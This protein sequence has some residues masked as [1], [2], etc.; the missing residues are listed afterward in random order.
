MRVSAA[1]GL[2]LLAGYHVMRLAAE[3][4]AGSAC[5]LYIQLSLLLPIG[6]LLAVAV[7]GILGFTAAWRVGTR[8]WAAAIA[9]TASIGVAGPPLALAVLRDSPDS[10][11]AVA[12]VLWLVGLVGVLAYGFVGSRSRADY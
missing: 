10:L 5:D 4:C 3:Q 7:A 12:T 11:V 2:V 8:G 6:V 9:V 1:A